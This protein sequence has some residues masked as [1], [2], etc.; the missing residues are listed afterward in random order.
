VQ[1]FWL[2]PHI[3]TT[4]FKGHQNYASGL[5][6]T[7]VCIDPN[8]FAH[9]RWHL[10]RVMGRAVQSSTAVPRLVR[11]AVLSRKAIEVKFGHVISL[12]SITGEDADR[13]EEGFPFIG[14]KS[15]VWKKFIKEEKG[16][17]ND[18]S[19]C[20]RHPMAFVKTPFF[21]CLLPR[22]FRL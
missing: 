7:A 1:K 4:P 19:G 9:S 2:N 13:A 3:F 5:I 22:Y 10:F 14:C 18:G 8:L 21:L 6:L 15:A 20:Q 11:C 17:S 12:L 16:L